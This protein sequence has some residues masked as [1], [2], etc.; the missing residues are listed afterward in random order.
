MSGLRLAMLALALLSSVSVALAPALSA[1]EGARERLLMDSGWRFARGDACSAE[2]DFEY[3]TG[4]P[5]AKDGAAPVGAMRENFDD[6]K[7]RAVDLPHDW[8][9]ELE[10]APPSAENWNL[11]AWGFKPLGRHK[12][13]TSI[14][15]YRRRFD[16]PPTDSGRRLAVEFDGVFRDCMAWLNGHFLGRHM[17]G[18]G[19]FA[20]DITDYVNY[21][22]K[23]VLVV[24]VDA[25]EHEGWW[26]EGAGIY[27]HVWLVKTDPVHVAH[28]GTYVTSQTVKGVTEVTARTRI[29]NESGHDASV[30]L[31]LTVIDADGHTAAS[32]K[33][34]PIALEA[35]TA[36]EPVERL[37]LKEPKR[38]SLDSPHMY[39]LVTTIANNGVEVDRGETPFGIRTI[40]F[41]PDQGFFLNGKPLKIKGVC[42]HQDHAGVGVALPDRI[43]YYRIEQ[44]KAMGVN[45]YRAAH[46]PPAPELLDA[47]D[48][49]GMLVMDE[50]RQM[51]SAPE[52]LDEL[53]RMVR[54]DRN[55]PSIILWSLGNEETAIQGNDKGAR[56]LADM[57]RVVKRLDPTRPVTAAMNGDWGKGF[58]TVVDIQGCNY[59][60]SGDVDAYHEQHP[61][62]PMIGTEEA[63]TLCTRGIYANDAA[64]GYVTAYDVNAP[65]WG[66]TAEAWWKF[67]AARPFIAGGFAWTGFDYRGE[68]T[69]YAWPCVNSHFGIMDTCGFPKDIYYY[70]QAWWTDQPVLHIFPHWNWPGKEGQEVAVWCYSNCDEVEL[71]LNGK[72]LGAKQV[73]PNSHVEWKVAYEPGVV[74][75]RGHRGGRVAQAPSP[76]VVATTKVETTGPPA[77]LALTPDRLTINADGEDVALAVAAVLD[78]KGRAVPTADNLVSFEASGGARIIGVGNGDP[79]SHEP[80]KAAQRKAFNGLC[81]AIVQAGRE[82]GPI[83]L[84]A[85]SPGLEPASVTIAAAP[86]TPRPSVPVP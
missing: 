38:W 1:V 71:F 25:T 73:E 35:W 78:D 18:Y 75:A 55:H 30:Q 45:A 74:E 4:V 76:V 37:P 52:V 61:T 69:P 19:S 36:I 58:S 20:Y 57:K 48:R 50:Q 10:F 47:C 46:N 77:K 3:G 39:R 53:E 84:T 54:R 66:S 56:V 60:K 59:M 15:W 31:I 44:L 65:A 43:Q 64:K 34:K 6:S 12:P 83:R 13:A 29:V 27:R 9:V 70:Y 42:C 28:W 79:S 86:A 51:G 5:W 40:T 80:D 32:V 22:G 85:T 11:M 24:R 8:A 16:L 68:P 72:S 33:S 17:S 26:Y 81:M 67:Y 82:A 23:N 14:G 63:S 41:D 49:L 21:G 2:R 7:W 62:Q